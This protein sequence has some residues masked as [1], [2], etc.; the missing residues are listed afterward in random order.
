MTIK[1]EPSSACPPN[2]DLFSR[3]FPTS[4]EVGRR[5]RAARKKRGWTIAEMAEAGGI[6]AVVI[7]S[8]E[9]GSRNM[10]LSRLGE[11]AAILNV[12]VRYLLGEP[13]LEAEITS[14]LMLDLRALARPSI[15][16]SD[17]RTAFINFSAGIVK[18]RG[19]WN[20]EILSLRKSD[21]DSLAYATS[22]AS[23]ELLKWLKE[24][25]YLITELNR[26]LLK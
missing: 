2:S 13:Q 11:I 18:V 25:H 12:D 21:L 19:D 8:Y 23:T 5:I 16:R 14:T 9:R 22:T 10:P 6:K 15:S 24:N 1:E 7:G 4:I 3:P 20:G 26:S 17:L